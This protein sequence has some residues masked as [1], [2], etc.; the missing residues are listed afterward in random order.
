MEWLSTGLRHS[1]LVPEEGLCT[2]STKACRLVNA[3]TKRRPGVVKD[4]G[5]LRQARQ[6]T[7]RLLLT[8]VLVLKKWR[9]SVRI[10]GECASIQMTANLMA[11]LL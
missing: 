7:S 9:F 6:R 8:D 4:L 5:M 10:N 11:K 2:Y 3:P 1:S